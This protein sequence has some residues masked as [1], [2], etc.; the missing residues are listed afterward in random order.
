MITATD[1]SDYLDFTED[2]VSANIVQT[3][4]DKKIMTADA[5]LADAGISAGDIVVES[6]TNRFGRSTKTFAFVV[7]VDVQN[8]YYEDIQ[9]E[10]FGANFEDYTVNI[11]TSDKIVLQRYGSSEGGLRGRSEKRLHVSSDRYRERVYCFAWFNI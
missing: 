6:Q 11:G 5:T 8:L 9:G 2:K 3:D 1:S 7:G 10:P 4:L